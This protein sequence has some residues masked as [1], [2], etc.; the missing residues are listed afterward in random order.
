M[1]RTFILQFRERTDD[2]KNWID[3]RI[4]HIV[5]GRAVLFQDKDERNVNTES[6]EYKEE[7]SKPIDS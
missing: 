5:S 7:R 2:S 6:S 4:E 3:G 1:D